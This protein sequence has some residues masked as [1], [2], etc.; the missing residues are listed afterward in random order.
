MLES[1]Q[2]HADTHTD[3]HTDTDT[4]TAGLTDARTFGHPQP[5]PAGGGTDPDSNC[6]SYIVG[7]YFSGRLLDR[8]VDRALD[9]YP[10]STARAA[11]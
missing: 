9:V 2:P 7:V 5:H 3:A 8:C 1:G 11:R 4:D 6:Y 10:G